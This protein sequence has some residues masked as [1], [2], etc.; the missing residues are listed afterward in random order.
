MTQKYR[1]LISPNK[2]A[3]NPV[4][5]DRNQKQKKIQPFVQARNYRKPRIRVG[6]VQVLNKLSESDHLGVHDRLKAEKH[7]KGLFLGE[8]QAMLRL[9]DPAVRRQNPRRRLLRRVQ[10]NVGVRPL[11]R[12]HSL[13]PMPGTRTH[14]PSATM[15]GSPTD[16]TNRNNIIIRRRNC[17]KE[18]A[19]RKE[20]RRVI[21]SLPF[22]HTWASS[23]MGGE[24]GWGLVVGG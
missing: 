18:R 15:K 13:I 6:Q 20:G 17:Q 19:M 16:S 22:L 21:F 1:R 4:L 11:Q 8:G 12:N 24:E 14:R 7:G 23:A 9:E 10:Y 5:G 3:S 2:N